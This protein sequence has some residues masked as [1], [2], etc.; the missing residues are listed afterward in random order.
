[1]R[2]YLFLLSFSLF[3]FGACSPKGLNVDQE[4][5]AIFD[6]HDAVMPKMGELMILRKQVLD[7]VNK[8]GISE[9]E[10]A[11][12]RDLAKALEEAQKGM[13]LWMNDW[14]KNAKPHINGETTTDEQRAFFDSEM[15]RVTQ[16][17]EEI[18]GSIAAAKQL[19]SK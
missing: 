18:N 8:E 7:D 9:E 14:S 1:M 16:V 3:A 5:N 19:L 11:E 12:R 2:N 6:V 10:Q 17:K 13:M 15:Q 4:V